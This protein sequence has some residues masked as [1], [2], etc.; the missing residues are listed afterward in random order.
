MFTVTIK[1][2]FI[3]KHQLTMADGQKEPLHSHDWVVGT[4]VCAEQLDKTGFVVDFHELKAN[5]ETITDPFNG[6]DI[7]ELPCFS[8]INASAENVAK[9]IYE[10]A[11]PLLPEHVKL[12]YVEVTEAPDC[13]AKYSR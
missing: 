12:Q 3:A 13:L 11:E 6:V 5:I 4:A 9:Y 7:E 10:M 8:G 1:T 2:T